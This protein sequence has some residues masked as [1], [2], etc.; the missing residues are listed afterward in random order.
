MFLGFED[1]RVMG[2]LNW[3]LFGGMQGQH[4]AWDG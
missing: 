2:D 4:P 1:I 3:S